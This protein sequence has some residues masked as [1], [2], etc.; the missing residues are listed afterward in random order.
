MMPSTTMLLRYTTSVENLSKRKMPSASGAQQGEAGAP[1]SS[2][3]DKDRK[4]GLGR[5]VWSSNNN[6]FT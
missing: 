3:R 4:A 1:H 6:K 5:K 2:I